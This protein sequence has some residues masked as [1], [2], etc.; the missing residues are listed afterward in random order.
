MRA[1]AA[2]DGLQI[3]PTLAGTP[4]SH[5]NFA[6]MGWCRVQ[7]RSAH[8][9][10]AWSRLETALQQQ[11]TEAVR[12]PSAKTDTRER[13]RFTKPEQSYASRRN[14]PTQ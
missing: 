1:L 6:F 10:M 12:Y 11:L 8:G 3:V 5:W 2:K 14:P 7:V 4:D 9:G 13:F